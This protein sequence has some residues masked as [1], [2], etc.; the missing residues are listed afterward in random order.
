MHAIGKLNQWRAGQ[1][2]LHQ[3]IDIGAAAGDGK[4][5]QRNAGDDCREPLA[6]SWSQGARKIEGIASYHLHAGKPRGDALGEIRIIFDRGE[7]LGR[8][9]ALQQSLR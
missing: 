2:P 5:Q 3:R 4:I 7:P 6:L 9:A 8:D 1:K